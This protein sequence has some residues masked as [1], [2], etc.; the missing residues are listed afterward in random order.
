MDGLF[1][2]DAMLKL[3]RER[4]QVV[5]EAITGGSVQDFA[6]YRHLRGKYE[7]WNEIESEL[8]SLL[9]RLETLDDE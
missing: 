1:M 3:V 5:V 8:R 9:K 4:R 7:V 6:A 2:A